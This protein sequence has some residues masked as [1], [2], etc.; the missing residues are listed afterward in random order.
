MYNLV[1][2][3]KNILF[4]C[5]GNICRSPSAEMLLRQKLSENHLENDYLVSSAGTVFDTAGQEIYLAAAEQLEKHKIPVFPHAAHHITLDEYNNAYLVIAMEE[6]NLIEIK[7]YFRK[8]SSKLHL[9]NEYASG[10]SQDIL[11]PMVTGDFAVAYNEIANGIEGL[12]SYL[13][14]A[15]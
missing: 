9:L 3:K 11:D 15:K 4:I 12:I 7:S 6:A 14:E 13:K 5:E 1:V 10:A 2:M 8:P